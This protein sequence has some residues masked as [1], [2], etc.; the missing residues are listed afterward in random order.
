M[1]KKVIFYLA[2]LFLILTICQQYLNP[3]YVRII[4]I[5]GIN[6]I[7]ALTLALTNGFLG[8]FSL[9]HAGF[10]AI[11]A[12][13]S[14]I[15]TLP[16]AK[17][18][19][20]LTG[21]PSWLANL[22]LPFI[23]SLILGGI[24]S[25]FFA[26]LIGVIVLRLRGHYLALSTLGFMVIV[27]GVLINA[28][29]V[30]KGARGINM[31]TPYTNMMGI[32]ISLIIVLYVMYRLINSHFGRAMKAIREDEIA[33]QSFG[34]NPFYYKVLA[35]CI[36]AFGAA[37]AGGLWAHLITAIT[38]N[39]FSYTITFSIVGMIIIGGSGSITG[40]MIGAAIITIFPELLRTVEQGINIFGYS[41][42]P[43][44]GIS[45]IILSIVI[46]LILV[47]RPGGI[48]GRKEIIL[49][50]PAKIFKLTK[51]YREKFKE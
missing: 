10:M 14:S 20:M 51:K 22:E 17:K 41:I 32:Y 6:M 48:M 2:I 23:F 16:V 28:S 33:A 13:V 30:T 45:Q 15:L 47:Y 50:D 36:G 42:P 37:F 39:A 27:R 3:Y 24:I 11:G 8:V 19:L 21:L 40:A 5:M 29:S 7:L 35:F 1:N 9:G 44:Y 4:N 18:V 34:I 43:L 49:P 25:I 38:P 31:L 12:Y 46:V 26:F